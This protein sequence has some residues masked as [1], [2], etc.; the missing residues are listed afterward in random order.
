MTS[1]CLPTSVAY[2]VGRHLS[3]DSVETGLQIRPTSGPPYRWHSHHL[4]ALACASLTNSTRQTSGHTTYSCKTPPAY[5]FDGDSGAATRSWTASRSSCTCSAS[6]PNEFAC[7]ASDLEKSGTVDDRPCIRA[8]CRRRRMHSDWTPTSDANVGEDGTDFQHLAVCVLV[9]SWHVSP[10]LQQ[11]SCELSSCEHS[12]TS[13]EKNSDHKSHNDRYSASLQPLFSVQSHQSTD[14]Y[15]GHVDGCSVRLSQCLTILVLFPRLRHRSRQE[16]QHLLCQNWHNIK[17]PY[18]RCKY[19]D[20]WTIR[21]TITSSY[22]ARI[23]PWSLL[24]WA[25]LLFHFQ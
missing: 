5:E 23:T 15:R 25:L 16:F 14:V 20:T 1:V 21:L 22:K 9:S 24:L 6:R 18:T 3:S 8:V 4:R 2:E 19:Y 12:A 17:Q 13:H 7:A 11:S 10:S